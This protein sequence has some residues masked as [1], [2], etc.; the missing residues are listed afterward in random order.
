[1]STRKSARIYTT[2]I[3]NEFGNTVVMKV[4]LFERDDGNTYVNVCANGPNVPYSHTWTWREARHL[5]I[6]LDRVLNNS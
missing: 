3:T 2:P 1:M 6:A 4:R 5:K